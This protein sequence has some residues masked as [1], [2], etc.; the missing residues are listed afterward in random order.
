MGVVIEKSTIK[1]E[2]P[3]IYKGSKPWRLFEISK[4]IIGYYN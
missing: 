3:V 1:S 2:S 4:F